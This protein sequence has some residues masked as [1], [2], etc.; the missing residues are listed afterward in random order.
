MDVF[1]MFIFPA[2]AAVVMTI[3]IIK[4][5]PAKQQH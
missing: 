5:P 3:V 4:N 2:I 1:Y